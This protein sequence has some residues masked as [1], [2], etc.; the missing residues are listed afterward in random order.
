VSSQ[1]PCIREAEGVLGR[2]FDGP[3]KRPL[4][5]SLSDV[6]AMTQPIDPGL[7][8]RLQGSPLAQW[9]L[10]AAVSVPLAALLETMGLPAALL[11]GPMIA[12]I[13][14]GSNGGTI[15]APRLPVFAAQTIVGCLVA[16]AITGDIVLRFLK[17]WP[18][19]LGVILCIVAASTALGWLLTRW[20]VLPGTTAVW[21][22]APG[23]ASVMMLMA[24]AFGA[25]A[26][27]VA[28]MQYLRVVL[29]AAV[30]SGVARQWLADPIASTVPSTPALPVLYWWHLAFTLM[31]AG[32][33][34]ALG[35]GLKIPAGGLLVPMTLA[36]VLE[37]LGLVT[38]TLPPWL[39]AIGYAFLGWSVGL[40]FTRDILLHASRVLPQIL[41]SIC[42]VI[43]ICALFAFILVEAAGID[44]M[45]AYLATCPGGVDS[46]AII[47]ASS[48]ADL[49]FIMTLQTLR[50]LVVLLAGPA[51]ARFIARRLR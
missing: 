31:I 32:L 4:G 24:G 17:D 12:G 16:R 18:L 21:G 41:F 44:P 42:A 37:G 35:F 30:A 22:V 15:R 47:G 19:F 10:L 5:G 3:W 6:S 20:Q 43:G 34:G 9:T 28:L 40:G 50:L 7:R 39:L 1:S 51:L 27:L 45:T 25:D 48:H 36:A 14:V 29:V 8:S 13:L 33:G 23:G 38:I 49:S 46:I 2:K 11:I 26:R